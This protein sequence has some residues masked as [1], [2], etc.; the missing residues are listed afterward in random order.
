[1]TLPSQRFVPLKPKPRKHVSGKRTRRAIVC[2]RHNIDNRAFCAHLG[3]ELPTPKAYRY[4]PQLW[5][6]WHAKGCP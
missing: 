5:H 3:L 2:L 1:M 6:A 4:Y